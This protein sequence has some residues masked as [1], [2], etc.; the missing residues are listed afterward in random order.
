ME[1]IIKQ[2]YQSAVDNTGRV[3]KID[4]K[5]DKK[6]RYIASLYPECL[7]DKEKEDLSDDTLD[8]L[9]YTKEA[10][11]LLGFR[12]ATE[13]WTEALMDRPEEEA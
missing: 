1:K 9:F 10:M 5:I 6:L 8:M 3:K 13:L 2:I 4:Q 12:Y 7:S 11:F